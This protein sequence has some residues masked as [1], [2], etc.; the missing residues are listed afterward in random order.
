MRTR[1][2]LLKTNVGTEESLSFEGR[3]RERVIDK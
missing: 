2:L 3:G 1:I